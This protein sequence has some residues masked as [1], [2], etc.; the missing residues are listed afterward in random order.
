MVVLA[1]LFSR[2]PKLQHQF[3]GNEGQQL[4]ASSAVGITDFIDIVERGRW[5][6]SWFRIGSSERR[7]VIALALLCF[8]L[9]R[10]GEV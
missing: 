2:Q 8:N 3:A 1:A 10:R 9:E 7:R 4:A 5:Y 6:L